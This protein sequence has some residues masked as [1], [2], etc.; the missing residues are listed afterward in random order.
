MQYI[1]QDQAICDDALFIH[2]SI[3]GFNF[4]LLSA[5]HFL[6]S[7]GT[8]H[9]LFYC[10]F[11]HLQRIWQG[12][13]LGRDIILKERFHKRYRHPTLDSK[14]TSQRLRQEVRSMLRSRKL[15]VPTPAVYNVDAD[16]STI[17]MELVNGQS[18]KAALNSTVDDDLNNQ[19]EL[20]RTMGRLVARLHDGNLVHG[21]LTTSNVMVVTDTNLVF[22]DFGLSFFSTV[23]ED[24]AVD[25]YVLERAFTSAHAST[26][27]ELF[28]ACLEAYKKTSRYWCST[29]NKF[30]EVRMR[31]RKR[32]MVG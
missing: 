17:Y 7:T 5:I 30:A 1:L 9:I 13:F 15:G 4:L 12:T 14:L 32:S 8:N 28:A 20:V 18:L 29:L 6:S 27:D 2:F 16:T 3:T 19:L 10:S 26:G 25:L 22:I 11:I 31:G 21:D 23:A 24:K